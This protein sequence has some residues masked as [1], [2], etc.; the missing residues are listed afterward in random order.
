MGNKKLCLTFIRRFG[1][2]DYRQGGKFF[3]FNIKGGC[4]M[5]KM[6]FVILL[7]VI[8]LSA[9]AVKS[10]AYTYSGNLP[11]TSD[12]TYNW[13][14]Y[15]WD[16]YF[17]VLE[18]YNYVT[19]KYY[20]QILYYDGTP[21]MCTTSICILTTTTPIIPITDIPGTTISLIFDLYL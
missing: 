2:N 12:W 14:I 7:S 17:H 15:S 18:L 5:K 4:V 21:Y 10:E 1:K 13:D 19:N 6:L 20:A 8:I 16:G 9:G 3:E 11:Y